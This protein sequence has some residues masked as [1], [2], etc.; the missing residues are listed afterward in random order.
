[1]ICGAT[2]M[3]FEYLRGMK[4]AYEQ[5]GLYAFL[6]IVFLAIVTFRAV[7]P[8]LLALIPLA[9]GLLWTLGFMGLFQIPFNIANLLVLP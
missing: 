6:G 2:G 4:E 3:N 7:Q 5:A 8:T 9:L 1:M